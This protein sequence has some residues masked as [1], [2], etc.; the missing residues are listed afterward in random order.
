MRRLV[1][2]MVVV[3]A[4]GLTG[5]A[6]YTYTGDATGGIATVTVTRG[7]Y[8]DI[9]EIRG[10]IQPVKSIYV[11][12]PLSAGELQ[13][14]KIAAN[15]TAVKSGD[16]VAEF[17][18]VT[19]RRTIQ[20]KQVELRSLTAEQQQGQAQAS[21]TAEERKAAVQ[22][23]EFDVLKAKLG[24][25]EIGLVAA[26]DAEKAKLAVADAEQRLREAQASVDSATADATADG[27]MR[28]R[29]IEKT[30]QDLELAERQVAA[31][32]VT[33]PT[34]G[35]VSILPNN[36]VQSPIGVAQEFRAG[37]RAFPGAVILELP[38]LSSVYLTARIDES[39][40]G[41]LKLEQT[42]AI[43]VDAIADRDYQASVSD[44]SV[45]AR[46]DFQSG[47][48]PPKQFDLKLSLKDPDARLRPGM[49][50]TARIT[51]GKI[52][53]VLLV[54]SAA[55]FY[56][57]GKTVVYRLARRGFEPIPVD[58]VRRGR[59]QAAV[60]GGIKDGDRVA[61][62]RPGEQKAQPQS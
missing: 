52:P 36:R 20:E 8:S 39:D 19:L 1:V 6:F 61:R 55:I 2:A 4:G 29:K 60:S 16:V 34:D 47:W 7:D 33:A 46:T 18:A 30:T 23:A 62:T 12:A 3:L 9:V 57:E 48:P 58:V 44:I 24:L 45:L 31:L 51:V 10:Q 56:E 11:T 25:G 50:A 13:I 40:R 42:A 15:G 38:D 32:S 43:R 26:I 22:K 37:D 49:S 5:Y 28:Q 21:I 59:E 17:D 53:N 14:M 41:K 54:P 27:N 35:L